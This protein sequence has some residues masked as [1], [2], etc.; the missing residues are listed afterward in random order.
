MAVIVY[1]TKT[2]I[3]NLIQKGKTTR[4]KELSQEYLINA[5]YKLRFSL[6]NDRSIHGACPADMLHSVLLG[7]FK[8]L[9][10]IFYEMLGESSKKAKAIDALAKLYCASLPEDQTEACQMLNLAKESEEEAK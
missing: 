10:S 3:Q 6:A 2:E 8:Y 9:L 7:I 1:K 5:F 4:L